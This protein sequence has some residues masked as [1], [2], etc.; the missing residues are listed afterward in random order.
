M[1]SDLMSA[2]LDYYRAVR[3]AAS[4][5]AF[6][7]VYGNLLA[8]TPAGKPPRPA[9]TTPSAADARAEPLVKEALAAIDQGGYA[10]AVARVAVL[11]SRKGEPL[12]LSRVELKRDMVEEFGDLL[13]SLAPDAV[14]RIRGRQEIIV[15]YEPDKA[16]E[17]LP[18]LLADR[19]DKE[20]MR[21]LLD[22]VQRDE[23]VL[24]AKPTEEQLAMLARIRKVLGFQSGPRAVQAA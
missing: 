20:R 12:Q 19:A 24:A 8:L 21:T 18:A 3:D 17:A 2:S 15:R 7:Q 6:F 23:R 13:P 11:L 1:M 5:A 10:E 4:E 16:V 22:R 14:R 9:A